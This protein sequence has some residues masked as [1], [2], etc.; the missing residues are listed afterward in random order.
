MPF[1]IPALDGAIFYDPAW[2]PD[3]RHLAYAVLDKS[4]F[5]IW[6]E[7]NFGHLRLVVRTVS[8]AAGRDG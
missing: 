8:L 3:G 4:A 6:Q 1:D 2:A 7:W 5:D